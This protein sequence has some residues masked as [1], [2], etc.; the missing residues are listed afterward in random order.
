MVPEAD[1]VTY[2]LSGSSAVYVTSG[3][4]A[5]TIDW[6]ATFYVPAGVA[7]TLVGGTLAITQ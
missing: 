4:V 3:A 2:D 5:K 1:G 7:V 6:T